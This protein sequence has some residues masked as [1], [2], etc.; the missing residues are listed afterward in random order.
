[1]VSDWVTKRSSAIRLQVLLTV[2]GVMLMEICGQVQVGLATDTTAY[3]SSLQM[4]HVLDKYTSQ[5][6]AQISV[7]VV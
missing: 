5:K 7:S 2:F 3:M 1:M 4:E 6:S